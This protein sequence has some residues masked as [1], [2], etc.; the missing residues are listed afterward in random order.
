MYSYIV[1]NDADSLFQKSK[2]ND[3]WF[4]ELSDHN[5]WV[6]K[7]TYDWMVN[8]VSEINSKFSFCTICDPGMQK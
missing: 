7:S 4:V 3:G 8:S 6:H 5:G 1:E 2:V